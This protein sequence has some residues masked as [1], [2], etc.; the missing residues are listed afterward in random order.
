VVY[1]KYF[2]RALRKT[3]RTLVTIVCFM[4]EAVTRVIPVSLEGSDT[5]GCTLRCSVRSLAHN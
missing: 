2:V 4:A 1:F 3:K 5:V